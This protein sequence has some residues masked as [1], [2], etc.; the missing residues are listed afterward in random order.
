MS[1]RSYPSPEYFANLNKESRERNLQNNSS[2]EE[3]L[4]SIDHDIH[5]MQNRIERMQKH[6]GFIL[7]T[8]KEFRQKHI[9]T[10]RKYLDTINGHVEGAQVYTANLVN[11]TGIVNDDDEPN[12]NA[13]VPSGGRRRSTRRNRSRKH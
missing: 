10:F 9:E 3:F 5:T 6:F 13:M 11:D 8:S 12:K 7:K 2:R 1:N 4:T